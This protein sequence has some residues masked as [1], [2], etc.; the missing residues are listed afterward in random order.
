[1]WHIAL[2]ASDLMTVMSCSP[3]SIHFH[4]KFAVTSLSMTIV[5]TKVGAVDTKLPFNSMK[6]SHESSFTS[7]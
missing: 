3:H 4:S 7:S 1:M 2:N 5:H 6:A